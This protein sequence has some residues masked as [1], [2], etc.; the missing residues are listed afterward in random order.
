MKIGVLAS[1]RGSNLQAIIDAI[2]DGRLPVTMKV[3]ISDREDAPALNRARQ[4]EVFAVFINPKDFPKRVEYD[5]KVAEVLSENG[6]DLVVL[7]GYMRLI[8][9]EFLMRFPLRVVNIHPSLLPAFPGLNPQEQALAYGVKFSGCTVHF[10]D[11]GIDTG[12]VIAQA[13][14]PVLDDDT[15]KTLSERILKEE[16]KLYPQVL[17]WIAAGRVLVAG[18]RVIVK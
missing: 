11:A 8:S 2:K 17:A 4:A 7:A 5:L 12:P 14:I 1:G 13:V 6:I 18:R 16:H 15:E 3:V 10:V 9:A